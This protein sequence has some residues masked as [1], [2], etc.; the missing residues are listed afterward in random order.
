LTLADW[1]NSPVQTGALRLRDDVPVAAFDA[2]A[3]LAGFG[4][5]GRGAACA[6]TALSAAG[7]AWT[8]IGSAIAMPATSICSKIPPHVSLFVFFCFMFSLLWPCIRVFCE[9]T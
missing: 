3:F 6:I 4:A 9:S 2:G 8:E 7:C 5:S 1:A